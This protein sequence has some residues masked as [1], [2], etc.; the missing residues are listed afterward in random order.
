[1]VTVITGV[2]VL[3]LPKNR[4]YHSQLHRPRRIQKKEVHSGPSHRHRV[5]VMMEM[6]DREETK[7]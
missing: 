1:M 7:E 6:Y 4:S 3:D 5:I 2:D